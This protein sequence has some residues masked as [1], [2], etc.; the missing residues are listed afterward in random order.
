MEILRTP[1]DSKL[2]PQRDACLDYF[3]ES[4]AG[5]RMAGRQP[6]RAAR[7]DQTATGH[8]S[9]AG[10]AEAG[11]VRMDAYRAISIGVSPNRR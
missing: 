5:R 6:L 9:F 3:F 1:P 11:A 7:I 10:S 8:S 2:D 4:F